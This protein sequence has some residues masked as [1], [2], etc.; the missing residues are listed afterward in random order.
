MWSLNENEEFVWFTHLQ[1]GIFKI[2]LIVFPCSGVW[3][4][5]QTAPISIWSNWAWVEIS[6][7]CT[8][9]LWNW[10]GVM[11]NTS[12]TA[13][14]LHF[15]IK[16]PNIYNQT[17]PKVFLRLVW[18]IGYIPYRSVYISN[19]NPI[20][21]IIANSP[22]WVIIGRWEKNSLIE[23]YPWN[24]PHSETNWSPI[25]IYMFEEFVF[26]RKTWDSWRLPCSFRAIRW[27][28]TGAFAPCFH[29]QIGIQGWCDLWPVGQKNSLEV[30]SA[31]GRIFDLPN[32]RTAPSGIS[33]IWRM[34]WI[35]LRQVLLNH[36]RS[37]MDRYLHA[38]LRSNG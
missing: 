4:A 15:L 7:K 10:L 32:L 20:G 24:I 21:F 25:N 6:Y 12:S 30:W 18:F 22:F 16:K 19:T 1:I 8:I 28:V 11:A 37:N 27:Q 2:V 5:L 36:P 33:M 13:F 34:I 14:R 38:F 23:F 31:L 26:E 35:W 17:L 29:I 3:T 9:A